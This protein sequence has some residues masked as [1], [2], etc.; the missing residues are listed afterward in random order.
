MA[1]RSE[2]W[3]AATVRTN[4]ARG[5]TPTQGQILALLRARGG[6]P[7]RLASIAEG[8]AVSP[9]TASEAVSA[10]VRKGLVAKLRADDDGRALGL[11]LTAAGK[12]AAERWAQWPDLLLGAVDA[13][14]ASERAL[15]LRAIVKIIRGL[16]ERGDVPVSRL[17]VTCRYFEPNRHAG[18]GRRPHHCAF[19]GAPIGDGDLRLDCDDHLAANAAERAALWA[20]FNAPDAAS[21]AHV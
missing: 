8:L 9:P 4:G 2:A 17:C 5:L 11:K 10:L 18:S 20:R 3:K 12:R 16:E 21:P 1:L 14:S 19:I 7:Q 6:A 15:F 13:L